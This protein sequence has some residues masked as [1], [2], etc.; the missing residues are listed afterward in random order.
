MDWGCTLFGD[1]SCDDAT[2]LAKSMVVA[3]IIAAI[4]LALSVGI[5]LVVFVIKG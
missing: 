2:F 5:G 1:A 3:G 4:W